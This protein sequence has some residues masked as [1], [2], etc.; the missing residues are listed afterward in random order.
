MNIN[1]FFNSL[2][3]YLNNFHNRPYNS[4]EEGLIYVG[5]NES[6]NNFKDQDEKIYFVN[7]LCMLVSLDLKF[8][9]LN[10]SNYSRFKSIYKIPKFEYGL[11]NVYYFPNVIYNRFNVSISKQIFKDSFDNFYDFYSNS[12]NQSE[13]DINFDSL[14]ESMIIDNHINSGSWGN[15]FCRL[16]SQKLENNT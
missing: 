1:D 16:I 9:E 4:A 7:Y 13:L 2:E 11:S 15:E 3:K 10:K 12:I 6:Y 5:L 8:Y 14:L